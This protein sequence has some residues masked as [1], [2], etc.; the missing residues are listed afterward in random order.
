MEKSRICLFI[1]FIL[2]VSCTKSRFATTTRHYHD[3]TATYT[4]HY[5]SERMNLNRHKTKRTATL[6]QAASA[7]TAGNPVDNPDTFNKMNPIA[8]SDKNFLGLFFP[9][10]E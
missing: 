5:S 10:L 7:K 8:S 1:I 9:F 2:A 4:N 6:T 3:G